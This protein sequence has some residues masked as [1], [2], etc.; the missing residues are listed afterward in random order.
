MLANQLF[1]R[2][3]EDIA[4]RLPTEACRSH[5]KDPNEQL[6]KCWSK[7]RSLL[8]V[9]DISKERASN[10][11]GETA[12]VVPAQIAPLLHSFVVTSLKHAAIRRD[13]M[14][15]SLAAVSTYAWWRLRAMETTQV[16]TSAAG[17][18]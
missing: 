17:I 9:F 3:A 8:L 7:G 2:A 5:A 10:L 4:T 15:R 1:G 11:T 14:T 12:S 6:Q 16:P 13:R 18:E